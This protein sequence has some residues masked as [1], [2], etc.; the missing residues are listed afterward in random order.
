MGNLPAAAVIGV[1]VMGSAIAG[2]LLEVGHPLALYD[3]DPG[4]TAPLAAKGAFAAASP[5]A[6]AKESEFIITSLNSAA[7]VRLAVFGPG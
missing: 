3:L 5:A 2:R 1:G 6:A 4:K 7:I